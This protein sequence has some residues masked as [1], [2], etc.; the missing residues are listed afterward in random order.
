M[1][2]ERGLVEVVC[3]R[4]CS[5]FK[6]WKVEEERCGGFEWLRRR[7]D[8]GL[9]PDLDGLPRV[10]ARP[11]HDARLAQTVC[12][13]CPFRASDCDYRDPAGPD[14]A[15]PCGGLLAI[16]ALLEI[17]LLREEELELPAERKSG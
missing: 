9:L 11:A 13:A 14:D 15:A 4:H 12:A 16:D 3:G 17:G 6:P 5:Y 2:T 10:E 8:R 1:G 7:R